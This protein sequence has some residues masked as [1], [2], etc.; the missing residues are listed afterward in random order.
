MEKKVL[1]KNPPKWVWNW[2]K[3]ENLRELDNYQYTGEDLSFLVDLFL[4]DFWNWCLQYVPLSIA[5]FFSP[6]FISKI[7]MKFCCFILREHA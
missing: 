3:E 7:I 4:R 5:Y 6:S 2:I 1:K